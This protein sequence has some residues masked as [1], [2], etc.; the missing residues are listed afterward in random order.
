M[1]FKDLKNGCPVF[2][3]DR[4]KI[5]FKEAN[6]LNISTP[7]F[8]SH[9]G[10]PTEMVVDIAIDGF[11]VPYTFKDG[12]DIGY[13]NNL[14][15]SPD[16]EKVLKEVEVLKLQSEQA[17]SRMDTHKSNIDKCSNI[18]S[19]YSQSFKEKK[20][21]EERFRKL[22]SSVGELKDMIKG[23]ANQLKER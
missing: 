18:L 4:D 2:I 12:T 22:E 17:L 8:D 5:E 15:I 14:V 13:V 10:N 20:E 11:Q 19:E 21:T 23:L 7:Y 9:F 1:L 3:F 6:V 16:R